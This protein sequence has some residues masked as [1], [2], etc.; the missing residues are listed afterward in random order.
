[1]KVH[2]HALEVASGILLI[3]VGGLVMTGYWATLNDVALHTFSGLTER[4]LDL[5]DLL[6]R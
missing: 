2:F 5:E 3:G 4:V 6:A 1:V